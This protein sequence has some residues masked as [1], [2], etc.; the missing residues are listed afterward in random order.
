MIR[1]KVLGLD[2]TPHR[3]AWGVALGFIIAFTPTLGFQII[4]YVVM[5]ALLRANK[6]SGIPWLFISNPLTAV[7]LY[8]GTWWVGNMA[9]SG[10]AKDAAGGRAAI[11]HMIDATTAAG[12]VWEGL[13]SADYWKQIGQLV[14]D[15]GYELW[16]GGLIVGVLLGAVMYPLAYRGV[17]AYR[18]R[19]TARK[20]RRRAALAERRADA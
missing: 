6:V 2:D 1:T 17:I 4:F 12:S 14:V 16:F 3:I 5:A 8:Y 11:Q 13:L 15:L 18:A 9:L 10:G 7:P 20:E 19:V